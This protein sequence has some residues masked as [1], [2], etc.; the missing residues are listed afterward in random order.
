[1]KVVVATSDQYLHLMNG[2]AYCFNKFWPGQEVDVLCY[3]IP[4]G[5]PA[6]FHT[7]SLGPM[8]K[9]TWSSGII[10]MASTMDEP[11]ILMLEDYWLTE[12]AKAQDIA[13]LH[14]YM[15]LSPR[16]GKI[17]LSGDRVQ[18]AH[19]DWNEAPVPLVKSI[20]KD[21]DGKSLY[22]PNGGFKHKL[23]LTSVQAAL[24]RW[25]FILDFFRWDEGPWEQEKN[26]TNR[27]VESDTDWL[28]LGTKKPLLKYGNMA[29]AGKPM[30]LREDKGM[31]PELLIE[32]KREHLA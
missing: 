26:G 28:L 25:E 8:E 30:L 32:L 16:I 14:H 9:H 10:T 24:W 7:R 18:F 3:D 11:F 1:M 5:M 31:T 12:E 2:F 17:D 29:K 22:R 27:I 6:N 23:F 20:W 15:M 21:E 19:V 13:A 4:Q